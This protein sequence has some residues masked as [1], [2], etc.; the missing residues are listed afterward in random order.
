MFLGFISVYFFLL[1]KLYPCGYLPRECGL[2]K[3]SDPLLGD[4]VCEKSDVS[5]GQ[6]INVICIFNCCTVERS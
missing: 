4:H 2:Y 3:A 1:I 5:S 6:T